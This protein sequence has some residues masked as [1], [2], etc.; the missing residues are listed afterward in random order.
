VTV[1]RSGSATDVGRVRNANQDLPLEDENLFAVADGMGGHAGGEVA[2]RV[3]MDALRSSFARQPSIEG[4]REAVAEANA[5]VWRASQVQSDLRG[6]GTTLTAAALVA[7]TDGRDV[8]ALANV[9]DSRAYLYSA[10][11]ITQVTDDHSLAEE[12][13]RKG[14][15]TEAEAAVHPHRHILTR[16]LGV[17]SDVDVD[18]WELHLRDGDRILICSDGLTNEVG[19]NQISDALGSVADPHEAAELLVREANEHGGNDNITV[20]VVDVLVGEQGENRSTVIAPV[21]GG[22][23]GAGIVLAADGQPG[24]SAATA[25]DAGPHAAPPSDAGGDSLTGVVPSQPPAP[26][27][28]TGATRR[29]TP[30]PTGPQPS[31]GGRV[32]V[33]TA[34]APGGPDQA[35]APAPERKL[36]RGE[37]RRRA[38]IPRRV[39]FRV[40]GFFLLVAAV[41]VGA[42]ALLRWYANDDWYVTLDHNQVVIYQGHPG[43]LLWFKPRIVDRTGVPTTGVLYIRL[44][45]LAGDVEEPSLRVAKRYVQNLQN[46][47]AAQ[48]QIDSGSPGGG[49][50]TTAIG[51][52]GTFPSTTL[53]PPVTTKPGAPAPTST[54]AAPT[55]GAP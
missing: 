51:P 5:A 23:A 25:L 49:T 19:I 35:P 44:N 48:Q 3:A 21:V 28:A 8:V 13:V 37:K 43:G 32:G 16:A 31:A 12:K 26:P 46:E 14:E 34:P 52:T 45:A 47:K 38:G 41:L 27:A 54:T 11:R 40:I 30:A 50:T 39:T 7:G 33:V 36:S 2:A 1:V 22:M 53:P 9:G 29:L 18:L 42:Y 17:S 15:L 24:A 55:P 20:V 6:M 10:G 4:L